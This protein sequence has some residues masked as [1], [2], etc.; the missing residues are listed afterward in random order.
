MLQL[1]S[2]AQLPKNANLDEVITARAFAELNVFYSLLIKDVAEFES[3][4]SR[5]RIFYDNYR[6]LLPNSDK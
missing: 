5:L 2:L 6:Q 4:I 3:A 1:D